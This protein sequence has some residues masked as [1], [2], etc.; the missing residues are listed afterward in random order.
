MRWC[1]A[2]FV[3]ASP[4]AGAAVIRAQ[5][6]PPAPLG[7]RLAAAPGDRVGLVW[8]DRGPK[9]DE[10]VVHAVLFPVDDRLDGA[11]YD[12][13]S[14]AGNA[15]E[16]LLP[17]ELPHVP[18]GRCFSATFIVT[19]RYHDGRTPERSGSAGQSVCGGADGHTEYVGAPMHDPLPAPPPPSDVRIVRDNLGGYRI[20][21]RYDGANPARF[22]QGIA[23]VHPNG[24]LVAPIVLPSVPGS[25]RSIALPAEL[26]AAV[27]STCYGAIVRVFAVAIDGA[28]TLP[29]NSATP[30]C[31]DG[32]RIRFPEAAITLPDTGSG[33]GRHRDRRAA[34]LVTTIVAA[35]GA[36]LTLA[37]LRSRRD[38]A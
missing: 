15:T 28:T 12:L 24:E 7:V 38:P 6:P 29:G 36:V 35:S 11:E 23:I 9:P 37:G 13:A 8:D 26:D 25:A 19:A 32:H 18:P 1:I 17:R 31:I 22:D 2:L 30:I 16:L 4:L 27:E 14:L 3:L 21:W 34:L 10:Y 20:T 33:G 5:E